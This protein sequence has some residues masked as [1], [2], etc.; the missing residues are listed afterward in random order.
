MS[1]RFIGGTS[2]GI[3]GISSVEKLNSADGILGPINASSSGIHN[4]LN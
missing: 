4:Y 2:S 1:S 3:R